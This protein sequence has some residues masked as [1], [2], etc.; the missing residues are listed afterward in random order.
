MK[1]LT[2]SRSIGRGLGQVEP[3]SGML[4]VY[5]AKHGQI[6]LDGDGAHSPFV[7]ALI[8]RI[9]TPR[10]EIR[11]LFDLVRDD[12]MTATARQQQPFSYG[13]VPGS[14]DFY[15]VAMDQQA[16]TVQAGQSDRNIC[17][18][19]QANVQTCSLPVGP[20]SYVV[21]ISSQ[22]TATFANFDK[23]KS[24][25]IIIKFES[26]HEVL[27][28]VFLSSTDN[29]AETAEL[30]TVDLRKK[31]PSGAELTGLEIQGTRQSVVVRAVYKKGGALGK[32]EV[33]S[34]N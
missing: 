6:A 20:Q 24:T 25:G 7:S 23:N 30:A 2:A 10:I 15:F 12:V 29:A 32:V 21:K 4:V 33:F 34:A 16:P 1:K 14:E 3:D 28:R 9:Q 27:R 26:G 13:S 17:V 5:A 11:K 19:N 31:L 8:K 18:S 22:L